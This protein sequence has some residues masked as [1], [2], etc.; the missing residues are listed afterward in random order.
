MVHLHSPIRVASESHCP[1]C[2]RVE[3][4]VPCARDGLVQIVVTTLGIVESRQ[5]AVEDCRLT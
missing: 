4:R 1:I 5:R 3:V 2:V